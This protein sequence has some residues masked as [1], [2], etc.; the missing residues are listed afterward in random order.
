MMVEE[1]KGVVRPIGEMLSRGEVKFE[2]RENVWKNVEPSQ[3]PIFQGV[4]IKTEKGNAVV[5]LS[6]DSQI[7]VGQSS[8]LSFDRNDQIH[9]IQGTINFRFPSAAE[10]SLKVGNFTVMK[11]RSLH[12]SQNPS[13]VQENGD[14]IG[15]IFVHSNGSLT[16]KSLQGSLSVINQDHVVLA[17]LSRKDVV[18]I[19]SVTANSPS[20]VMVAQAVE[21]GGGSSSGEDNSDL[22]KETWFWLVLGLVVVGGGIG[23]GIAIYENNKGH[24]HRPVPVCP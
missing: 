9:L 22:T 7:E 6:N 20:K 10:L 12:A 8:L 11:Y 18:T 24:H 19:P 14:T 21:T 16:V 4:K 5:T 23:A 13:A 2:S 1:A 3:F 15:S 17:T